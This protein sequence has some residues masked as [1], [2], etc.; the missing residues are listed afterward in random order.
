MYVYT[1]LA[2]LDFFNVRFATIHFDK[3]RGNISEKKPLQILYFLKQSL[4]EYVGL[5]QL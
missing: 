5:V 4:F 2:L 3:P 1:G